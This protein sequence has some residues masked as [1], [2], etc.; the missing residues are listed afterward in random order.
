MINLG[1]ALVNLG[2]DLT[3]L[4]KDLG[5]AEKKTTSWASNLGGKVAKLAGG[6]ILGGATL[7]VG[8]IV[9]IG[10]AAFDTANAIDVATGKAQAQLGFV[11]ADAEQLG[12]TIKNVYANNFGESIE[13]V[14]QAVADVSLQMNKW[15]EM[16][17]EE[18]G[19]ATEKAISFR[20]AFGIEVNE[21]TQAANTLM[22]QFGL[23]SDE[24]FTFIQAGLQN[25]LNASGDFLDTI[26]EYS[27]QFH[28]GGADAGEFFSVMMTGLQGGMLG[29]DK[30]ADAF[31]EFRV[32][33][34]DGS[35]TTRQGLE[36]LGFSVDDF[37]EKLATGQMTEAE[38]FNEVRKALKRTD[39]EA[40]LMQAG[41]ALI[42]TQFEDLGAA[43]VDAIDLAAV[44]TEELGA[45]TS[46]MNAQYNNLGT[47][48]EGLKRKA[49]IGL[50]PI[51]EKLVEVVKKALPLVEKLMNGLLGW[52]SPQV[53]M[54][55]DK[56][57]LFIDSLING[58]GPKLM[59]WLE[60][61]RP[62]LDT[63]LAKIREWGPIILSQLIPGLRQLFTWGQSL[64]GVVLPI[65]ARV[66]GFVG[67][68]MKIFGPILAAI[69]VAILALS[70][71]VTLIIGAITLLATAWA[72]N[73]GGI[74]EKVAAVWAF[75]Q[76][77]FE[78]IRAW[79]SENIPVA[80]E[81]LK[82]FWDNVFVP[83]MAAAW[84]WVKDTVFPI[85][86]D[87]ID[88]LG[89][90]IPVAIQAL[91]DFWTDTLQPAINDVWDFIQ[92]KVI[93]LFEALWELLQV[94]GGLA[95]TALQGLWQNVLQP[96]LED[97]W[98]FIDSKLMPIFRDIWEFLGE[99][100]GPVIRDLADGALAALKGAFEGISNAIDGVI[101]WL[102]DM[103][104][105]LRGLE[106]PDWLTPGSPTPFEIGLVGI[107]KVL[108][109]LNNV[110]LPSLTGRLGDLSLAQ[111]GGDTYNSESW[112]IGH[113]T[114][115]VMAPSPGRAG[116]FADEMLKELRKRGRR[117]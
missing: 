33:I 27:N 29:T 68:N 108:K 111:A 2:A 88:W 59:T 46:D 67:D 82:S 40:T 63:I 103:A 104:D 21:S 79:L 113:L 71:P 74:Q 3:G 7:A 17:T 106:L 34:Q 43:A 78:A 60:S 10:A 55:A 52:L 95:I 23:T 54:I 92:T 6:A 38:A 30:A 84:G 116:D 115:D 20:D 117:R 41:V 9:G 44:K 70:S 5:E 53:E 64:A 26:G 112:N 72:N 96:A 109:E 69:G 24:A 97:I 56:A 114:F 49:A 73:W 37:L 85:I 22:E 11:T 66:I 100:L 28:E 58:E 89:E 61:L 39:D 107:G 80:I 18:L 31:K 16:T 32:R 13:D 99:T 36:M 8:A 98:A 75:V 83:A 47:I 50:A 14:G 77:V 51:G 81:A 4:D 101:G 65:L 102:G 1:S 42:G 12:E 35:E 57:G 86:Q 76:P 94:A 91:A 25:G 19:A 87:L 62:I 105:K 48:F 110:E 45:M 15:G 90:N 93:P